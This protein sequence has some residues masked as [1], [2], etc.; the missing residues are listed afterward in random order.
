MFTKRFEIRKVR[1]PVSAG[2]AIAA[3]MLAVAGSIAAGSAQAGEP[4]LKVGLVMT[5]SGPFAFNGHQA[6]LGIEIYKKIHGDKIAGR[7]IEIVRKDD[8]GLAPDVSKRATQELA[9]RDKVDVI[10]GGCWS[11]NALAAAPVATKA[12]IP[13]FVIV[14][15]SDG[16]PA[17]SPYMVRTSLSLSVPSYLMGVWAA[18]HGWKTGYNAVADY[19]LG[20]AAAKAFA[21][22]MQTKGGKVIGEVRLPVSNPDFTPYIQR[23]KDARPQVVQ[24]SLPAGFLAEGFVKTFHNIGLMK[25]GINLMSGDLNE[26]KPTNTLGDY[27]AGLYTASYYVNDND[28]PANTAFVQAYRQVT[29]ASDYP[30]F[31]ALSAYDALNITRQVV[32]AQHG[33]MD[34]DKTMALLHGHQFTSP[35]GPLAFDRNGEIVENWY[36]RRATLT[37]G[38]MAMKL[39]ETF[40]MVHAPAAA[41]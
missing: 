11:P 7:A 39:L 8:T 35:R 24:L 26:T 3:A 20:T 15:A 23:I 6:D 31:V 10:F 36:L 18:Q 12:K 9:V 21:H 16:I 40:P 30:G 41:Q 14:A 32:E 1:R 34:P 27:V 25:L 22:G 33:K 13:F 4:P 17:K 28:S 29:G 19:V 2:R 37:N 38:K 5:Y